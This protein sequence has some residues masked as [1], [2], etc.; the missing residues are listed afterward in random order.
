M[1]DGDAW[2]GLPDKQKA[3]LMDHELEHFEVK[4]DKVGDFVMDDLNRPVIKIR[5]HDRQFGWFDT[6]AMRHRSDS[7]EVHQLRKLFTEEG[8][9]YLPFI[10]DLADEETA[11][12]IEKA[13]DEKTTVSVNGGPP[14]KM[15]ELKLLRKIRDKATG[16]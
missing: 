10:K 7:M 3:A 5:H 8:Q 16:Q 9:V 6:I 15:T 14:V 12:Q 2:D 13:L 1:L 11:G 4:R